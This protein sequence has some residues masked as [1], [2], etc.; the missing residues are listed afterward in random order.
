MVF[1]QYGYPFDLRMC[2][3][4]F[5]KQTICSTQGVAE[6]MDYNTDMEVESAKQFAQMKASMP[7]IT[8]RETIDYIACFGHQV[9]ELTEL[10]P[11]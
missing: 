10:N 6:T 11:D 8:D 2:L 7:L 5:D 9:S 4:R 3:D 1:D